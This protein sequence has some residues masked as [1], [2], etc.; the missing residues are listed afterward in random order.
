MDE[1]LRLIAQARAAYAGV[2]DY[3]CLLV[4]RERI[5]G[6]L[7][8]DNVL[9]MKVRTAPFSVSLLWQEPR[10]LAGQEVCY[11]AGR[12]DGMMR[13]K[14]SGLL[15]AIG[16]VSLDPD[17]PRAR[18]TSRHRITEAGLGNLIE[19][20]ARGWEGERA[21]GLTQV[22]LGT[23]EYNRRRCTRV[24]T[25]HPS[26]PGG[27][28]LYYRNVV[29]FDQET[30]LPIRVESYDWPRRPGDP[31]QLAEVFSYANLRLNVGLGDEPFRR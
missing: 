18:Q 12:N 23:Y 30:H 26:N 24:E 1:P 3:T 11:V 21:L 7:T 10:S 29:Y 2:R 19:R 25:I 5:G 13:V 27:K 14:S 20:F 28:F 17:D 16:F 9:Q 4:K 6:S 8:P 31:G 22:R 15:G